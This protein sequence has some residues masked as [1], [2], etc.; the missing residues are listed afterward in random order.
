MSQ[1]PFYL[2]PDYTPRSQPKTEL[3]KPEWLQQ[4]ESIENRRVAAERADKMLGFV[5]LCLLGLVSVGTPV[6]IY[7]I[8]TYV[9]ETITL[10]Y[11]DSAVHVCRDHGGVSGTGIG[12]SRSTFNA[13]ATCKDG[14]AFDVPVTVP[15]PEYSE[16]EK[17]RD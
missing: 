5:L 15:N 8:V 4:A 2:R 11:A 7:K 9:P 1:L 10:G 12:G 14:S 6:V 13:V 3:E 16:L 17:S